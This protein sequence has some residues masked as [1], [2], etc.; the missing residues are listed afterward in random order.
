VS[1][2]NPRQDLFEAIEEVERVSTVDEV[3]NAVERF[4]DRFGFDAFILTGL[5]EEH[6]DERAVL[7][8]RW[9]AELFD[10]YAKN[11]LIKF[12]P[13]ARRA[14]VSAMPFC[15]DLEILAR[16]AHP[17]TRELGRYGSD[18]GLLKGFV[19][20]IHRRQG[21][22]A[23]VSFAGEQ[24]EL[25]PN[26]KADLH[27]LALYAFDRVCRLRPSPALEMPPL[28]AR[29]REVLTWVMEGKTAWEIGRILK[30]A[31]RTVDQHVEHARRKLG[32][33]N[34]THAVAV[35]LRNGILGVAISLSDVPFL[36]S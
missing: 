10:L 3:M 17:R 2:S 11:D 1:V 16:G 36:I 21:G 7:E 24:P 13:V 34:R 33:L 12:D 22:T 29:E 6:F 26:S 27:L 9:P 32:A 20:P 14:R 5:P 15:W 4:T 23:I 30:I 35:A 19:V 8:S 18:F 25:P 28:T 31:K